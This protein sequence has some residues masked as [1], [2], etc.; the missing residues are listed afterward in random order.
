MLWRCGSGRRGA[1][2]RSSRAGKG[3]R[4]YSYLNTVPVASHDRLAPGERGEGRKDDRKGSG[5]SD[6]GM[7]LHQLWDRLSDEQAHRPEGIGTEVPTSQPGAR[8]CSAEG[9]WSGV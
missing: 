7:E 6:R 5:L 1:G 9:F 4:F 3:W 8:G 2:A